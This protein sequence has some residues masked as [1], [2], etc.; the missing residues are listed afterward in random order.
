MQTETDRRNAHVDLVALLT[1]PIYV[2]SG[3]RIAYGE[4]VIYGEDFTGGK[5]AQ[6]EEAEG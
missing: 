3:T 6:I 2:H 5:K 4:K 1:T